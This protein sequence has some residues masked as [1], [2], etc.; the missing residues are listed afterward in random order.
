[1]YELETDS[2]SFLAEFVLK[3]PILRIPIRSTG[4]YNLRLNK[5]FVPKPTGLQLYK[6]RSLI[7]IESEL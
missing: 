6:D 5:G 1:M 3:L 2:V 7:P 4:I